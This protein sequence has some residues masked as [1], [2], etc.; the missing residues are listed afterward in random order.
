MF[1]KGNDRKT[2]ITR[3]YPMAWS[4]GDEPYYP[5]NNSENNQLFTKYRSLAKEKAPQ[6]AFGGRLGLYRYYNMDQVIAAALQ[7]L[8][9]GFFGDTSK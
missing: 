7:F 6:V 4:R 3:E 2:V 5:V 1:G 8:N 9:G